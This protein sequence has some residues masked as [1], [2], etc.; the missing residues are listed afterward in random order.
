MDS[1]QAPVTQHDSPEC[2]ALRSLSVSFLKDHIPSVGSH[3]VSKCL[4]LFLLFYTW[5]WKVTGNISSILFCYN[6]WNFGATTEKFS[7]SLKQIVKWTLSSNPSILWSLLMKKQKVLFPGD[8]AADSASIYGTLKPVPG[9][10]KVF[11][12]ILSLW[13]QDSG[14]EGRQVNT[15]QIRSLQSFLKRLNPTRKINRERTYCR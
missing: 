3:C 13:I 7:I 11:V 1:R 15:G 12:I 6:V 10:K 2:E 5:I 9:T 8:L 4:W 14:G